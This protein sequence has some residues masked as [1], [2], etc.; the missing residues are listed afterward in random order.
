MSVQAF[1]IEGICHLVIIGIGFRSV[2]ADMKKKYIGNLLEADLKNGIY[3]CISVSADMEKVL[4]VI[5]WVPTLDTFFRQIT[6]FIKFHLAFVHGL[7]TFYLI[8]FSKIHQLK[9]VNKG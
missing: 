7:H 1:K 3:R 4:S 9:G 5:P 8:D 6:L 2:L